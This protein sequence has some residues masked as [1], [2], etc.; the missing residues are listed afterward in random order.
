[1]QSP[2]YLSPSKVFSSPPGRSQSEPAPFGTRLIPFG[3]SQLKLVYFLLGLG[4]NCF[5][6]D[7]V[8]TDTWDDQN[9]TNEDDRKLTGK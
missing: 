4:F 1:M 5:W 7:L 9:T 3:L 8:G 2:F 6:P